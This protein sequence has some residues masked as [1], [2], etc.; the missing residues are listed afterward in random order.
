MD[1]VHETVYGE[2][3]DEQREVQ[4][5]EER[6]QRFWAEASAAQDESQSDLGP[7]ST[8]TA[9]DNLA[10][11]YP[12]SERSFHTGYEIIT[13]QASAMTT[14]SVQL[15]G[16]IPG[17]TTEQIE[18]TS[19]RARVRS[20]TVDLFEMHNVARPIARSYAR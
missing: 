3:G 18:N 2:G 20:S 10:T 5:D 1:T 9:E 15:P 4:E 7:I 8:Y 6:I 16:P 14:Q 11:P 19:H 17:V 13:E 12:P